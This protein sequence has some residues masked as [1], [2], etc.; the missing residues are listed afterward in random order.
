MCDAIEKEIEKQEMIF[1]PLFDALPLSRPSAFR[2]DQW[3]RESLLREM[4]SAANRAILSQMCRTDT[5]LLQLNLSDVTAAVSLIRNC[6]Y[7][8]G[9]LRFLLRN[10]EGSNSA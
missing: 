5:R 1:S 4:I 10:R 7:D 3:A 6:K 8:C 2:C 9:E